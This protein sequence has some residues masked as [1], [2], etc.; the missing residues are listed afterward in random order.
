MGVC[1]LVA[2]L[3][4]LTKKLMEQT[5]FWSVDINSGTLKV[6]LITGPWSCRGSYK[7]A[8]VCLDVCLSD[9]RPSVQHF[10]R[11]WPISFSWYL[12]RW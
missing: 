6:S 12:A 3:I 2:G 1:T 9:R 5:G 4:Y 7:V 11:E 8:I 10:S